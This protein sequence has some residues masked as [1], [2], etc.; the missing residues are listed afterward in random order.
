MLVSEHCLI[1]QKA[2]IDELKLEVNYANFPPLEVAI[3]S[4]DKRLIAMIN[5]SITKLK[6]L[7]TFNQL[8]AE[9][10]IADSRAVYHKTI[11]TLII[12]SLCVIVLL[13]IIIF[14]ARRVIHTKVGEIKR[15]NPSASQ[16]I[17]VISG[18]LGLA[19][20]DLS[21]RDKKLKQVHP[22][23]REI[24]KEAFSKLHN[25]EKTKIDFTVRIKDEADEYKWIQNIIEKV[26][27][28]HAGYLLIGRFQNVSERVNMQQEIKS[29][30]DSFLFIADNAPMGIF[31]K[32]ANT[33]EILYYNKATLDVFD[34]Q[35]ADTVQNF[36]DYVDTQDAIDVI[37]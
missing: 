22:A 27:D 23:D 36:A 5:K 25:S 37:K 11:Y 17:K 19:H 34:T 9:Y 14:L 12:I 30:H 15:I 10:V 2:M 6:E 32:D 31:I 13:L 18:K 29:D 7:G 26:P 1:S 21:S 20:I 8:F 4:K 16:S 24:I 33:Q 28:V 3:A 35:E